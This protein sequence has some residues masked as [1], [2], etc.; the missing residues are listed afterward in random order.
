M[1]FKFRTYQHDLYEVLLAA[2]SEAIRNDAGRVYQ[3][4]DTIQLQ[5]KLIGTSQ[6]DLLS[7][8]AALKAAYR[9]N[10]TGDATFSLVDGTVVHQWL[11]RNTIGGVRLVRGPDFPPDP[12]SY[13]GYIDYAITLEA[14]FPD[15]TISILSFDESL[16][17]EGGGPAFE[18]LVPV[19]GLPQ[20]QM[21]HQNTPFTAVQSGRVV[22]HLG[23]PLIPPPIW[24]AALKVAP[25]RRPGSPRRQGNALVEWPVE[26]EYLFESALPLVGFPHLPP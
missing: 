12:R 9:P 20:K 4:R 18:H 19:E 15:T 24:P 5:G 21:T 10:L 25:R 8:M 13:V 6:S 11:D 3:R 23:Y 16:S 1:R 7:K 17:F 2:G 22:G 14:I 26:Y